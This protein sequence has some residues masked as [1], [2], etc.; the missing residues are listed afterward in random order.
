MPRDTPPPVPMQRRRAPPPGQG[1][2]EAQRPI[3]QAPVVESRTVYEAKPQV[4]N[5]RK[6][7][8]A[9][10]PSAV[11]QK[12]NATKG[13][14]G[15]RLLEA[16]ELDALERQGYGPGPGSRP[17]AAA[18]SGPENKEHTIDDALASLAAAE[19]EMG[20]ERVVPRRPPMQAQVE[21]VEDEEL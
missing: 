13:K 16:D 7:A 18:G 5:L 2:P 11:R 3:E 4:K 15:G 19:G 10:V 9:F 8:A 12:I 6:E 14:G 17:N 1:P 21:E 20:V